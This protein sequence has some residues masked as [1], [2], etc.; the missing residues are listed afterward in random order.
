MLSYASFGFKG[1]NTCISGFAKINLM[2]TR[3]KG[4]D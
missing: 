3:F 2:F 1:N 4:Y